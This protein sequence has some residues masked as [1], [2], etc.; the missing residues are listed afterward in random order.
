MPPGQLDATNVLGGRRRWK[1]TEMAP[2]CLGRAR[3]RCEVRRL[4]LEEEA[5]AMSEA[6]RCVRSAG[7]K[8]RPASFLCFGWVGS[9]VAVVMSQRT[10]GQT[11]SPS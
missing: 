1:A 11:S 5:N 8:G 2:W 3:Y 6:L 7:W 4:V 10:D 9:P